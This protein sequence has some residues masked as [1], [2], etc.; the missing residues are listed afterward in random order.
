VRTMNNTTLAEALLAFAAMLTA[1]QPAETVAQTVVSVANK[2]QKIT[3]ATRQKVKA[4]RVNRGGP[5][6]NGPTCEEL[7]AAGIITID[8]DYIA[9]RKAP[10]ATKQSS[11][12]VTLA[13]AAKMNRADM[14]Q[15]LSRE[16][17]LAHFA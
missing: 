1:A 13:D 10:T 2:A 17:L 14:A 5:V 4:Q 7:Y 9:E 11:R 16:E 12:K 3:W 8:G 15:H 6:P